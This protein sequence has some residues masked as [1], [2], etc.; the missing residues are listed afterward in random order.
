VPSSSLTLNYSVIE[1]AAVPLAANTEFG[2]GA[3]TG[4]TGAVGAACA[5]GAGATGGTVGAATGGTPIPACDCVLAVGIVGM[6][7][8]TGVVPSAPPKLGLA[9]GVAT[10][11]S[12]YLA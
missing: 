11:Y 10:T 1:G 5:V 4:G 8:T 3:A 2:S 7:G 9:V 6:T 12:R